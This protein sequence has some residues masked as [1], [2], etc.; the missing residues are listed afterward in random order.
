MPS[1]PQCVFW[2]LDGRKQVCKNLRIK[3]AAGMPLVQDVAQVPKNPVDGTRQ[4]R[5]AYNKDRPMTLILCNNQLGENTWL[6]G[7]AAAHNTDILAQNNVSVRVQCT[8]YFDLFQKRRFHD[9]HV[10]ANYLTEGRDGDGNVISLDDV[11]RMF[12]GVER[13]RLGK[14][15]LIFCRNGAN[16]SSVVAA[17]YLMAKTDCTAEMAVG[18]LRKCRALV[19]V[20]DCK[21]GNS[22]RPLVW[23]Q[24][25]GEVFRGMFSSEFGAS[26]RVEVVPT[27]VEETM[28][29]QHCREQKLLPYGGARS[30]DSGA[31]SGAPLAPWAKRQ[32]QQTGAT[33]ESTDLKAELMAAMAQTASDK[34][35]IDNTL[36]R[37][38]EAADALNEA[39]EEFE[40]RMEQERKKFEEHMAAEKE[41]M[42]AEFFATQKNMEK[43]IEDKHQ[44]IHMGWLQDRWLARFRQIVTLMLQEKWAEVDAALPGDTV[45]T[46][47]CQLH[48]DN[49]MTLLH[50]ACRL[51][52]ETLALKLLEQ[53]P[54]AASDA[55]Y[56]SKTPGG[57]TPLQCLVDTPKPARD[58]IADNAM[59]AI[60]R[61]LLRKMTGTAL[62][63]QTS[64]SWQTWLHQ[65]TS[66]G[67]EGLIEVLL[68]DLV[69]MRG[70]NFVKELVQTPNK[71]GR[72]SVDVGH[73]CHG[74]IAAMLKTRFRGE[75]LTDRD[76]VPLVD[77]KGK[78]G[79]KQEKR[80]RERYQWDDNRLSDRRGRGYGG[81]GYGGGKG[82]GASGS[83]GSGH[84]QRQWDW[85]DDGDAG[86][87]GGMPR[88]NNKRGLKILVQNA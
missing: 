86:R 46:E 21:Y 52:Q 38:T 71:A 9:L 17:A 41:K 88:A 50:H 20:T 56:A 35:K 72:G 69:D 58:S 75:E 77:G 40:Q 34:T 13:A 67:Q 32:Q 45:P 68:D 44:E 61:A 10:P 14:D 4:V 42:M 22:V 83:S 30:S 84:W 82:G 53:Y 85:N 31:P 60:G 12:V 18:H 7:K 6:G 74:N 8:E 26:F 73:K 51:L 39:K 11:C 78:G 1:P 80:Q 49:G 65:A 36:Q 23:L 59:F 54:L 62:M 3:E 57:W 37:C 47:L 29:L 24:R 43:D 64:R 33:E 70:E 87:S 63:N 79:D 55:T 66:R 2:P 76:G 28:Y 25:H 48:D 19:D 15:M 27:V 81:G 16:R 5:D